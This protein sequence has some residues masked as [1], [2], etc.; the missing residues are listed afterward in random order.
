MPSPRG[1]TAVLL[2]ML[3]TLVTKGP[4]APAPISQVI[5]APSRASSNPARRRIAIGRN[6]SCVPSDRVTKPKPLLALNHFTVASTR[7]PGTGG[8]S[9]RKKPGRRSYIV[10][11]NVQ[12]NAASAKHPNDSV[13][14][15]HRAR[16]DMASRPLAQQVLF[17][18]FR[19]AYRG[20]RESR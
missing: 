7:R 18:K 19:Q 17:A 16:V 14:E 9:S 1:A 5:D 15:S 13:K 11:L 3:R 20:G 10:P 2:S 6:A 4:L 12:L 8:V